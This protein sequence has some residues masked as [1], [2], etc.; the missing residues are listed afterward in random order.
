MTLIAKCSPV[1][2]L[3]ADVD[4]VL[5]DGRLIYDGQG[6]E[7]KEFHIRDGM[8]VRL[9]QKAGLKFGLVTARRSPIVERRAR[10][11]EIEILRQGDLD[12][13][14]QTKQVAA[15]LGVELSQ[16]CYIGDDLPDLA[17]VQAVGLG[18]AVADSCSE[19]RQ[20]AD[21]VTTL[22]GGRGAVRE[23]VEMILQTTGRWDDLVSRYD[24]S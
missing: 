24:H 16:I 17:A 19:V 23:L 18:A 8:G 5:T 12:K 6:I 10:E 20:A 14:S 4:G 13:L 7:S 3:L 21:Y 2:L 22:P 15:E 11:L 9:W 1:T